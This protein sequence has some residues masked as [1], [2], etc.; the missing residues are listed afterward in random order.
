MR[1]LRV[2]VYGTELLHVRMRVESSAT[3]QRQQFGI[4]AQPTHSLSKIE[5]GLERKSSSS[6]VIIDRCPVHF[7]ILKKRPLHLV[8]RV[9]Q[10]RSDNVNSRTVLQSEIEGIQSLQGYQGLV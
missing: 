9:S 2:R 8:S 7:D 1:I 5:T 4:S 10:Q 3:L 6:S